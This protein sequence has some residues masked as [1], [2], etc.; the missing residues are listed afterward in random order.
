[1]F[2]KSFISFNFYQK[3]LK[4]LYFI[5]LKN[6]IM[7]FQKILKFFK[8]RN[9]IKVFKQKYYIFEIEREDITFFLLRLFKTLI[10]FLFIIT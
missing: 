3:N 7:F 4:F 1:M 10:I 9:L 2:L 6:F 8:I 5:L